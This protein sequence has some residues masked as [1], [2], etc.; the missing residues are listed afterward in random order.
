MTKSTHVQVRVTTEEKQQLAL[1]CASKGVSMS[2][3]VRDCVFGAR[4]MMLTPDDSF[5]EET[6][7]DPHEEQIGKIL[8]EPKIRSSTCVHRVPAGQYCKRCD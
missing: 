2:R 4:L 3:Y 5:L 8:S 1:L 6:A 7:L